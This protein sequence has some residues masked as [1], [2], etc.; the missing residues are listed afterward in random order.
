V[1]RSAMVAE[2]PLILI[3][4]ALTRNLLKGRSYEVI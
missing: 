4:T 3:R 1:E 2:C